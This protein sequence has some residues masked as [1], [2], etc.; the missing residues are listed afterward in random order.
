MFGRVVFDP[1]ISMPLIIGIGAIMSVLIVAG[2]F[3]GA[4]A[5]GRLRRGILTLI[6]LCA[7]A[8][9]LVILARP[10]AL[11][12]QEEVAQRPVFCVLADS[13]AS[14]NT[15]DI[16]QASR[17]ETMIKALADDKSGLVGQLENDYD[18]RFY[19]FDKD[20]RH[21]SLQQLSSETRT[22]GEETHIASALMNLARS[23][24]GKKLRSVLLLSDGRSNEIDSLAS[25]RSV[26]RHFRSMNVPVWSVPLGTSVEAKDVY[27]TA[28]L[29]SNF[30]FV[31]QPASVHVTLVGTGYADWNA[32]VN[33]Y[34]EDKYVTSSQVNLRNGAGN[35][36][37]PIRE[38]RRGVIQY[39]VEVEPLV[40]ESDLHNNERSLIAKVIDERTRV[41][42]VEAR[43]HWDS[44]FLLRA[45]RADT[46]VEVTSIFHINRRKTFAVVERISEDNVFTKTV[47]PGIQMPRTR[48]ELFKYDCIFLGKDIQQAFTSSEL[49]LMRDYLTDRG[50]SIVFFRGKPY[51]DRS[52]ELAGIEPVEWAAETL[53]DVRFELTVQ[54]KSS[55]IFNYD[56]HDRTSDVII[57]ELPS[58]TSVTKVINEKSLAVVLAQTKAGR[59]DREVATVAYQR[60]GKGKVMSIGASGL[61]QWGFLPGDLQE[62]DDVYGRFWGQMIR[63][64]VSD[65][66][67]LPGQDISFVIDK[68]NCKPGDTVHIGVRAKLVDKSQYKPW[69]ELIA[70]DGTK[71]RLTPQPERDSA[72]IYV[73]RYAPEQQG[74]YKATLHN[75]IGQPE[76]DTLRFT[77]YHDSV[78]T[79][80]VSAD[81][82]FLDQLSHTTGGESLELAE[83]GTLPEKVRV[84]EKLSCVRSKPQDI[85][86]RLS[87]FGALVCLLGVEWFIRR[88]SGLV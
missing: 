80:Y 81:R 31:D 35:V 11:K 53:R 67:F 69:V 59:M 15:K 32:K 7:L 74:E 38:E 14:M 28:R 25:V 70:P 79:R 12:P 21:T 30:V 44:K 29:G 52:P 57:R 60:Y 64:L 17:Y 24:P 18:L 48:D 76:Q 51:S 77:V 8:V 62:Y 58:M 1:C 72:N 54:G 78:E 39:R 83:L 23:N 4:R 82:E 36:T 73:A 68:N 87:V 41:L 10:M 34:R 84:F 61:W 75:N 45:L 20:F 71:T 13:S 40:G 49:K 56:P 50:G 9:M 33:L 5:A 42:V 46:N 47:A 55:P 16:G 3:A 2:Y 86:D 22:D 88:A 85:W 65:S 63:W 37:F 43:P 26:G 66:E 27:I 19:S 6:R